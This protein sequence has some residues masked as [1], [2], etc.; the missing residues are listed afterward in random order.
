MFVEFRATKLNQS[1]FQ[2][3][4]LNPGRDV[5]SNQVEIFEE[6]AKNEE[7]MKKP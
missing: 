6:I 2:K 5:I 7:K 4:F 1:E 3:L